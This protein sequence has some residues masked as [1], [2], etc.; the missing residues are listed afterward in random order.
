MAP[1]TEY[2]VV[3]PDGPCPCRSG[4]ITAA[5]CMA[6]DGS[7]KVKF[8]SPLPP[9]EIMGISHPKCYMR[10][11]NNCSGEIATG[12]YLSKSLRDLLLARNV[13]ADF[14]WDDDG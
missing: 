4:K 9:G 11:T 14:P 10:E 2:V 5:C 1:Q 6:A 13:G 3:D 8:A 7:F 12:Y